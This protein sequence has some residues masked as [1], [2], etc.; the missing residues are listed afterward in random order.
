MGIHSVYYTRIGIGKHLLVIDYVYNI[1]VIQQIAQTRVF[2]QVDKFQRTENAKPVNLHCH[3]DGHIHDLVAWEQSNIQ[4]SFVNSRRI[5]VSDDHAVNY[6]FGD[7]FTR[8]EPNKYR[9]IV[10]ICL[11]VL[12]LYGFTSRL[13]QYAQVSIKCNKKF[14]K[15]IKV[16]GLVIQQ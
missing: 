1:V 4:S 3:F 6:D 9:L 8:K 14:G 7:D 11:H 16:N 12:K 10:T 2:F 15:A 13:V 5:P